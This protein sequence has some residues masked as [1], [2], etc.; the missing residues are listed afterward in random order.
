MNP[1][2]GAI[3]KWKYLLLLR[4]IVIR[5]PIR[6]FFERI[7]PRLER[8]EL[9]HIENYSVLGPNKRIF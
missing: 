2:I 4:L 1:S 5:D 3:S 7:G 6:E 8:L 9:N